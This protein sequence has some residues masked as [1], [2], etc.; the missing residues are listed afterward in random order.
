MGR[1]PFRPGIALPGPRTVKPRPRCLQAP[2]R[3]EMLPETPYFVD[4][5]SQGLVLS[6]NN[7]LVG[8]IAA[9]DGQHVN[10]LPGKIHVRFLQPALLDLEIGRRQGLGTRGGEKGIPLALEE[11][12]VGKGHYPQLV[13]YLPIDQNPAAGVNLKISG[14]HIDIAILPLHRVTLGGNQPATGIHLELSVTGIGL[15]AG[16]PDDEK[17]RRDSHPWLYQGQV[18]GVPGFRQ[19]PRFGV[20]INIIHH[21]PGAKGT[22]GGGL[23]FLQALEEH[24]REGTDCSYGAFKTAGSGVG[25]VV[26]DDVLAH[27]LDQHTCRGQV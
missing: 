18:R 2:G 4:A 9:Q 26:A 16:G 19:R 6:L 17:G 20:S 5:F 1:F 14:T 15:A 10:Q 11:G 24:L 21:D 27:L 22:D 13:H 12:R 7:L 3:Q 8:F 25:Q 23:V